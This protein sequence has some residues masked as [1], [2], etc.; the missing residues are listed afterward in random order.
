MGP[1]PDKLREEIAA[2]VGLRI[3]NDGSKAYRAPP[4]KLKDGPSDS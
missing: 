3:L 2:D 4:D 1:V